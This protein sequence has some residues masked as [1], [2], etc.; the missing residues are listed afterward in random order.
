MG[1]LSSDIHTLHLEVIT[2]N[3]RIAILIHQ[4]LWRSLYVLQDLSGL[5]LGTCAKFCFN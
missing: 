5:S 1:K 4:E 2:I 3:R